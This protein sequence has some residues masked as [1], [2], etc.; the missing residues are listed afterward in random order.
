MLNE[1][2]AHS[3]TAGF[4]RID[5]DAHAPTKV[6]L[7][8]LGLDPSSTRHCTL[9]VAVRT[10]CPIYY[11]RFPHPRRVAT[12]V[13]YLAYEYLAYEYLDC[14]DLYSLPRCTN[15]YD[16][17]CRPVLPLLDTTA[18]SVCAHQV[19]YMLVRYAQSTRNVARILRVLSQNSRHISCLL[20]FSGLGPARLVR[21]PAHRPV[22][23]LRR[24]VRCVCG[25]TST[26][27]TSVM[28]PTA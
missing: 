26:C 18:R 25:T 27:T 23:A 20:A 5:R 16:L 7:P 17:C 12:M 10:A 4:S 15:P 1:R 6:R 21:V 11:S 22:R 3:F 19:L 28:L 8:R 24:L 13:V 9:I 14:L 2:P